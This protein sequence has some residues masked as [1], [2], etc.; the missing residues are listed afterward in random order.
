L[1]PPLDPPDDDE[2]DDLPEEEVVE[3]F[4]DEELADSVRT[5]VPNPLQESQSSSSAPSTFVVVSVA[6]SEPHIS[7]WG[8]PRHR[9]PPGI[10]GTP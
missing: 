2:E 7:H 5:S 6:C 10:K 8:I 9:L 1:E 4:D 3:Y